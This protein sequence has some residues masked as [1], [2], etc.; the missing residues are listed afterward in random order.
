[1]QFVFSV[2]QTGLDEKV[3]LAMSLFEYRYHLSV[4]KHFRGAIVTFPSRDSDYKHI[5]ISNTPYVLL[6]SNNRCRQRGLRSVV[7]LRLSQSL[8]Q[9]KPAF[10]ENKK[11]V[12]YLCLFSH[13]R[14]PRTKT[15]HI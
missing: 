4:Y 10:N 14:M 8:P 12:Y 9:F 2:K 3:Y 5:H 7:R 15:F 11:D 6:N 1:M 13:A